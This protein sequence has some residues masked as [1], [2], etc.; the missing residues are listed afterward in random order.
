MMAV[1]A[2]AL[3]GTIADEKPANERDEVQHA[4]TAEMPGLYWKQGSQARGMT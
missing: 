1:A 2:K 4:G 3:C